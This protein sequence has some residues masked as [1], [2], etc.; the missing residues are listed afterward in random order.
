[1]ARHPSSSHALRLTTL[2]ALVAASALLANGCSGSSEAPPGKGTA[3]AA[4]ALETP[5]NPLVRPATKHPSGAPLT[6][7]MVALSGTYAPEGKLTD[8]EVIVQRQRIADAQARI[9]ALLGAALDKPD[10]KSTARVTQRYTAVPGLA[11]ELTPDALAKLQSSSDVGQLLDDGLVPATLMQTTGPSPTATDAR[12]ANLLPEGPRGRGQV[13]A[14]LDTGVDRNHPFLGTERF[15][16]GACFSSGSWGGFPE[17]GLCPGGHTRELSDEA[18]EN[19][20][21]AI[22]GCRH[23]THVAGIIGGFEDTN[24]NGHLDADDRAGV[25]PDASFVAVQVFHSMNV[26]AVCEAVGRSAPCTLAND[27]DIIAGLDHV[28]TL[29]KRHSIAAVNLS[30]GGGWFNDQRTCDTL[31]WLTK[32][33]VDDLFS[34]DVATVVASANEATVGTTPFVAGVGQPACI[35]GVVS[36]GNIR[37]NGTINPTSQ[38]APFLT[39][40]APGTSVRSSVP[41]TGFASFSGTSMAAPHVAGTFALMRERRAQ[42]GAPVAIASM[43][44]ALRASGRP[45][46][47]ARNGVTT[48]ALDVPLALGMPFVALT[49]PET[50]TA[51]SPNPLTLD[52]AL[53]RRGVP[54]PFE[55]RVTVETSGRGTL[56]VT[57]QGNPVAGNAATLQI[58]PSLDAMGTFVVHVRGVAGI[59]DVI[60]ADTTIEVNPAQ[61]LVSGFAPTSGPPT[62]LVAVDGGGFSSLTR[63]R[64]GNGPLVGGSVISPSRMMVRVPLG[65]LTGWVQAVNGTRV[66]NSASVF[67]VTTAPAIASVSPRY[68]PEGASIVVNG[69]NFSPD[70]QVRMGAVPVVDL[71]IE[72]TELL[73]FRIPTGATGALRITTSSGSATSTMTVGY[74]A[75]TLTSF[76]PTVGHSGQTITI[77]GSGFFGSPM[78]RF[79]AVRSTVSFVSSTSMRVLVPANVP[80]SANLV[81]TTPGG[82]VT[83]VG[84]F[85]T[86]R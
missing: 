58:T 6:R 3:R 17:S 37:D 63:V 21:S 26:A 32:W 42:T 69:A 85:Q 43:V 66:A 25:A 75:P 61:P 54:G 8:A 78:V 76:A 71:S 31:F 23:G 56:T 40:L 22:D 4:Q 52:Y 62:T 20:S 57:P 83:S 2:A 80:D 77:V 11:L 1:M 72:S 79:G 64:F 47:D 59:A 30:L 60:G 50:A 24:G 15:V 46:R 70:T 81:V 36:V 13:V 29:S 34:K 33:A 51:T 86:D 5:K 84:R 41:G 16:A 55:V 53:E 68:A 49:G 28:E 27:S 74:P 19:C 7:I 45:V 38:S 35:S 18:G 48:P 65:G 14:V 82:S 73:R 12:R 9:I 10:A 67:T 44:G 39:L